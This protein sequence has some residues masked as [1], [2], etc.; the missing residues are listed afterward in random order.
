MHTGQCVLGSLV[1]PDISATAF[2]QEK[3]NRSHFVFVY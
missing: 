2:L 3:G 1:G